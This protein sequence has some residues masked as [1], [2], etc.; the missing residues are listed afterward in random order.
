[1]SETTVQTQYNALYKYQKHCHLNLT[2]RVKPRN[3]NI[4]M[5]STEIW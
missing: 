4:K 3:D 5:Y 1:M 2:L